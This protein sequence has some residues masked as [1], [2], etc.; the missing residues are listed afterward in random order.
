MAGTAAN[1]QKLIPGTETGSV[2]RAGRVLD[3]KLVLETQTDQLVAIGAQRVFALCGNCL[4]SC[5]A[6]RL[7][8]VTPTDSSPLS[9]TS[10][11]DSKCRWGRARG[12]ARASRASGRRPRILAEMPSWPIQCHARR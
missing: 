9:R 11:L 1:I 8:R 3:P 2:P 10:C 6:N 4:F 7:I 12:E 5:H